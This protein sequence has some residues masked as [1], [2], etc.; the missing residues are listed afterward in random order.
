MENMLGKE[1]FRVFT[2]EDK[3][4]FFDG[5]ET[6]YL[7]QTSGSFN[8]YTQNSVYLS[9][10]NDSLIRCQNKLCSLKNLG[11][12]Y[13]NIYI[14]YI[15]ALELDYKAEHCQQTEEVLRLNSEKLSDKILIKISKD[16]KLID[17]D[18]KCFLSGRRSAIVFSDSDNAIRL[19]GCGNL[20][21]GFNLANVDDL[22]NNHL[23]IRGAQFKNTCLREQHVTNYAKE[24]L[25]K[26]GLISGNTPLG[27][28]KYENTPTELKNEAKLC[29]KYCGVFSTQG[30]KRLGC[31]FFTGLNHLLGALLNDDNYRKLFFESYQGDF[32]RISNDLPSKN[33]NVNS[34]TGSVTVDFNPNILENPLLAKDCNI[35]SKVFFDYFNFLESS[36]Q[37]CDHLII[38]EHELLT[39]LV[40]KFFEK[41]NDHPGVLKKNNTLKILEKII[42]ICNAKKVTIIH[43]VI[44]LLSKMAYE[45]GYV[46]RIFE[47]IDLNWGTY[48]Y[49]CNAHL[50]NYLVIPEN[51]KKLFLAPL[52][53][54]LGFTRGHFVDINYKNAKG[55]ENNLNFDD[56]LE[57]EKNNLIVQTIGINMIPNIDVSV[58]EFIKNPSADTESFLAIA[59]E[60]MIE[61]FSKG[62]LKLNLEKEIDHYYQVGYEILKLSLTLETLARVI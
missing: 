17:N 42:T 58:F 5:I 39:N 8:K 44:S 52:D 21:I 54:D 15:P 41:T 62:Y 26:R 33:F 22:G 20:F 43:C 50:D 60:N 19:K 12:E 29:D 47:E 45:M 13:E 16:K 56:L 61:Y 28:Y 24:Q 4:L 59:K 38:L 3:L 25:E 37:D 53:F 36:K 55:I 27:F 2:E 18:L 34:D 30:D 51:E 31:H 48:D 32:N 7:T 40:E 1:K 9:N 49:H 6:G 11:E 35:Y 10:D 46:K 23:E 14:T 57:R